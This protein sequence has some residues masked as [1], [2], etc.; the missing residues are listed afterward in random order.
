MIYLAV[1]KK[2]I[3]PKRALVAGAI[4]LTFAA[5]WTANG[6]RLN[7]KMAKAEAA[8]IEDYAKQRELY[9]QEYRQQQATDQAAVERLSDD[10]EALRQQRKDLQKRLRDSAVVKS[11]DDICKDGS[12]NP[13][14]RDFGRLWNDAADD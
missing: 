12:G 3:T 10:L 5:G 11:D 2:V 6:W 1:L 7:A 9:L 8:A 4:L 13:F 14:G